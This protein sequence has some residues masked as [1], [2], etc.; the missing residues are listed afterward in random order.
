MELTINP[1]RRLFKR[2]GAK[3]VS[4]KAAIE[5]ARVIEEK[6]KMIMLEAQKLSVHSGRRT[7]LRRDIKLARKILERP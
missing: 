1:I 3:R 5:L 4:D 2:L 6:A 7:V